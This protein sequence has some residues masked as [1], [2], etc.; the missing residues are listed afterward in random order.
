MFGVLVIMGCPHGAEQWQGLL[1]IWS[2][3]ETFVISH[4][5]YFRFLYNPDQKDR[6][7]DALHE[8]VFLKPWRRSGRWQLMPAP[9]DTRHTPWSL[10]FW[11]P[12]YLGSLNG[13]DL[14]CVI[15]PFKQCVSLTPAL[16]SS[17][18]VLAHCQKFTWVHTCKAPYFFSVPCVIEQ[19]TLKPPKEDVDEFL[20]NTLKVPHKSFLNAWSKA[21]S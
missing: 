11:D 8:H 19:L 7:R 15:P 16:L 21:W 12:V 9:L 6:V 17:P 10:W 18:S 4:T 5:W 14:A 13:F 20:T 2:W 1:N 3:L